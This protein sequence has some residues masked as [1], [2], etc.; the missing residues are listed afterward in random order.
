M[1]LSFSG[2]SRKAA[3]NKFHRSAG[4]AAFFFLSYGRRAAAGISRRKR[5][6]KVLAGAEEKKKEM[7]FSF[8][9]HTTTREEKKR[10]RD[11]QWAIN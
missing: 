5:D 9:P 6:G 11:G 3:H 1:F 8:G 4:R 2:R 10:E 7:K